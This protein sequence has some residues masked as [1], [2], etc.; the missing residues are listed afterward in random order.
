MSNWLNRVGALFGGAAGAD[1]RARGESP[2]VATPVTAPVTAL[3]A[4]P[5]APVVSPRTSVAEV[6]PAAPPDAD[7]APDPDVSLQWFEWL[8]GNGPLLD[9]PL[10]V[11]EQRV[12]AH[13]D[14][15]LASDSSRSALLP[16]APAVIPQLMNCLRDEGRS[17]GDLAARVAKDPLLVAEVIRLA[18][19]VL[20]GSGTPLT[21]LSRAVSR[22]GTQGLR[23][24]IA[25]VVLKPMFD[26]QSDPLSARAAP[27]LWWHSEAQAEECMRLSKSAGIDPFEGYLAGLMHNIG[28]TAA[29]RAMGRSDCPTTS[30]FSAAFA[31]QFEMRC[32]NFFALLVM[33]WQLTDSL[34]ALAAELLDGSSTA[35]HSP[36]RTALMNADR[37]ASLRLLCDRSSNLKMQGAASAPVASPSAMALA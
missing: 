17:A 6:I 28:W 24:A 13:L 33:P 35:V 18:N 7:I 14:A 16:R 9:A 32:E 15:V 21:D 31:F 2:S 30:H 10:R 34:T 26:A 29:L 12:L 1:R 22:I 3:V 23:R 25:N 37:T 8:I 19:S 36:L 4:G 20:A 5:V 27:A 11:A